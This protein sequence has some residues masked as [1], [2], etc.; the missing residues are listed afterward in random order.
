MVGSSVLSM[1]WLG[2]VF[3]RMSHCDAVPSGTV[4]HSHD[5]TM[6]SSPVVAHV[7]WIGYWPGCASGVVVVVVDGS[8][9]W[10]SVVEVVWGGSWRGSVV[11]VVG[12]WWGSVVDV[13]WGG[14]WCG[15]VV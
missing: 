5:T 13:V 3:S 10:G 4:S 15:S 2:P 6:W 9:W 14:S 11:V 7:M 8:S 12:S 1:T